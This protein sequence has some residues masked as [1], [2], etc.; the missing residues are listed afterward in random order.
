MRCGR[1]ED[2][3][4]YGVIST[5]SYAIVQR[6]SRVCTLLLCLLP[7][8]RICEQTESE[9]R[10]KNRKNRVTPAA[11][12]NNLKGRPKTKANA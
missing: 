4:Q 11:T 5:N 1:G 8:L 7:N 10:G 9:Q 6:A 2:I 12:P 3:I